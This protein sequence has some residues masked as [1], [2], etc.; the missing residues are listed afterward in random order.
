MANTLAVMLTMTTY[1]TWLRGDARG[2]VEDG[3]VFPPAPEIEAVDRLRMKHPVYLMPAE[4]WLQIGEW[5]GRSLRQ[6]CEATVLAL[7]V[8]TW[9]VHAVV[10]ANRFPVAAMAKCAK[11]AV[12][13]G[14]RAGRP[15]WGEGYDKRYCYDARSVLSRI[16]YV[17]RHNLAL[18]RPAQPW[19]FIEPPSFI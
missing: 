15:I 18:G 11:D 10:G 12:R 17:E 13:W 7:F 3:V 14:L 9:H 2:W 16:Q 1:G 6:R 4:S 5:V 19:P 8:G